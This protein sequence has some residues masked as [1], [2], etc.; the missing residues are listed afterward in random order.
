M[1]L[2]RLFGRHRRPGG[3]TLA[4]VKTRDPHAW[5]P[6]LERLEQ[7]DTPSVAFAVNAAGDALVRFDTTNLASTASVTVTG[8]AA[9]EVLD[10]ITFRAQTGQFYAVAFNTTTH[11]AQ[12]GTINLNTGAFTAIGAA[13]NVGSGT[14]ISLADNPVT[15]RLTLITDTG[16]DLSINPNDATF[17]AQTGITGGID[18]SGLAFSNN[19]K[20]ALSTTLFGI[21]A[22]NN[23]L[24]TVDTS[25][26][27][28]ATVGA[29]LG[30][31]DVTAAGGMVIQ[32]DGTALANLTVG[33]TS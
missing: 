15:D 30:V 1:T 27:A 2:T 33:G 11:V 17:T 24:V 6:R 10:G 3:K 20:G 22:T 31:G 16:V 8:M 13:I 9:G 5:T 26:G 32:A 21:D 12:L 28:V 29:G 4:P 23:A 19:F 7:R 25:T 18:I 14:T